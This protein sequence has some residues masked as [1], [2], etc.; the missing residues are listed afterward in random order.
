MD[1][2]GNIGIGTTTPLTPLHVV[3]QVRSSDRFVIAPASGAFL[4]FYNSAIN[5]FTFGA[6]AGSD[7]MTM[8]T[9]GNVGIGT[10]TPTSL[11]H[12]NAAT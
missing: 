8:T 6:V 9:T 3:G 1:S 11:L 12:M 7:I 4:Q 5:S 2:N 10:T